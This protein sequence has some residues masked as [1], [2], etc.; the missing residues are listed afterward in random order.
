[1]KNSNGDK[2]GAELLLPHPAVSTNATLPDFDSNLK[3]S[4]EKSPSNAPP[5]IQI[6]PSVLP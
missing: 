6:E 3:V 2:K 1:M 5:V 4:P